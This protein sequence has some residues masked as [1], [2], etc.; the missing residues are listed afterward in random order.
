MDHTYVGDVVSKDI[1]ATHWSNPIGYF[2]N[3]ESE[4]ICRSEWKGNFMVNDCL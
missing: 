2:E 4:T 1:D 3:E